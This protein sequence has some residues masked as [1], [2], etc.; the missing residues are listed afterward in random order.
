MLRI[1]TVLGLMHGSRAAYDQTKPIVDMED[2]SKNYRTLDCW[3]CFEASGKMCHDKNHKSMI[4]KTGS[5]VY[6][7]GVCCKPGYSG[8]YC[9]NDGDH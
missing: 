7:Q 8:E 5:S 9:N 1:L 2:Y 3:E 6:G 4:H